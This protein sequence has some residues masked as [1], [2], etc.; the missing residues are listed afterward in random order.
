MRSEVRL[1]TPLDPAYPAN[2]RALPHPPPLFCRGEPLLADDRSVAVVGT[3]S[4]S[5]EG[6]ARARHLAG[7]LANAGITV[8]S[9][10]A[11]GIDTAAHR[12]A[13][14]AGGRSIAVLGCG[15]D[16]VYP[17]ENATLAEEIALHGA[18]LS[19]LPAG[20][21]PTA[22]ALRRRNAVISGLARVTVVV[23]AGATSGAR[24]AA[25]NSLAQGRPV[26]LPVSLVGAEA[27]ASRLLRSPGAHVIHD[28]T[29]AAEVSAFLW[30]PAPARAA[31]R[32][33]ASPA[34]SARPGPTQLA[35]RWV[36]R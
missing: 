26:L 20:S 10:L 28:E 17:A 36:R 11:R 30:V 21:P 15:L 2:L 12:A 3:R 5:P 34:S 16:T 9:G 19:Q 18:V 7:Q 31:Q 25:R 1:L 4:P 32:A 6:L 22:G 14:S 23:E 8:V 29:S 33:D 27:W 13:L 24:I 35:L